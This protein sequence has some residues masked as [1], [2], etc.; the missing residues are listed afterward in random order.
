M[1]KS[2]IIGICLIIFSIGFIIR[3]EIVENNIKYTNIH[4]ITNAGLKIEG[5][6]AY[7]DGTFVAGNI[8]DNYYCIFGDG[9][10]YIVY[11]DSEKAIEINKYLLDNPESSYRI[12]GIT[13]LIPTTIEKDGKKFVN[14][15]LD[16]NHSHEVEEENHIHDITTDEFY[17][18]FGYVYLDSTSS[19]NYMKLVIYLIGIAGLVFII[20]YVNTKYHFM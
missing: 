19:F 10:Q 7:L 8:I 16:A 3:D 9:V 14:K 18:Y 5:A 1:K 17:H 20:N 12:E 15:W 4:E 11:I 13:K 2:L 6:Y